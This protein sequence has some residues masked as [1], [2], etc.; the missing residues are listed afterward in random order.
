MNHDGASIAANGC[1][2]SLFYYLQ[3]FVNKPKQK[4][5]EGENIKM[6]DHLLPQKDLSQFF[7]SEARKSNHSFPT[8][9]DEQNAL[10]YNWSPE[11]TEML[12]GDLQTYYW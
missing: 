11:Y 2:F 10:I 3:A 5:G 6:L 4:R 12:T 9:I 8:P 1:I 7:V